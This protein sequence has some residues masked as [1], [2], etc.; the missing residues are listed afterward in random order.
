MTPPKV[1]P[2][3][4]TIALSEADAAAALGMGATFFRTHV[5][6]DVKSIRLAGKVL[7]PVAELERWAIERAEPVLPRHV[8]AAA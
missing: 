2:P 7:Y 3:V 5:M 1:K 8:K 4:P 6:P